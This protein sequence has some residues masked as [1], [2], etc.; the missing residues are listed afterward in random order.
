MGSENALSDKITK[1]SP[2]KIVEKLLS[3]KLVRLL[4]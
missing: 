4:S 3:G 2:I 1:I